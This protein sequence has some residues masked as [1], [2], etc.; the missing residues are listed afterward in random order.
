[1]AGVS[2]TALAAPLAAEAQTPTVLPPIEANVAP[3]EAAAA[4]LDVVITGEALARH[5]TA[6]AD[7]MSIITGTP[8]MAV[9]ANGGISSLPVMRGLADS[10]VLVSVDGAPITAFCPNGMNPP[11]SYVSPSRLESI[12]ILPTLSPVSAGGDNIAGVIALTTTAPTF[13]NPDEGLKVSGE[14]GATYR[15]VA[16]A[17]GASAQVTV[18]GPR[19]SVGYEA[20]WNRAENYRTGDGRRVR[21]TLYEAYEQALTLAWLT[22]Q[23]VLSLR[24]GKHFAPYEGFP[25]QRMDLTENDSTFADLRYEAAYGWG[26][27]TA[28]ASWREV[29]HE[30]NFLSDKGGSATGGMPMNSQGRD[31]SAALS[32][33]RPM[34]DGGALRAGLEAHRSD[35]DDW[36]PP[37]AGSAMMSPQT[38][39]NIADGRRDRTGVWAEW[40]AKPSAALTTL[41]GA[42]LER[43]ETD[44][45]LVQPYSWTGMMNAPDATAARIFNARDRSR[46]DDN[47]DLTAKAT[48][49]P[50]DVATLEFGY[51]RK[52]RSPNLYERYAWGVGDMSSS[53]TSFVGDGNGYVGDPD[54]KPEVAHHLA[55]TLRLVDPDGSRGL[56][57]SAYHSQVEDLIDA[58]KLA[59]LTRGFVKLR[60]ANVDARIYGF[61]ASGFVQAW[62]TEAFGRGILSGTLA[63]VD[64]ENRDSGDDLYHMT[65]LTARL[66]L[67]QSKG[68]WTNV[69]EVE[70][71]GEKD[72]VNALRHEPQT[73]AYALLNLR[74]SWKGERLR[75][76]L[77]AENLLDTSYDLPLGGMSYG[78]FRAGGYAVPIQPLPGPGRSINLGLTVSF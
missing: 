62:D 17:A 30:M 39:W 1:M 68:R 44:T 48:W 11:G 36:W 67:E 13:A 65:P 61:D 59:D 14:V 41:I 27:L 6:S 22:D 49:R 18:A 37:V 76:D 3:A 69:A 66:A 58:V 34:Q 47:V 4:P 19:L 10:R 16:D 12:A 60:F 70:L 35:L 15:S 38:Y 40:E 74:T 32:A 24:A 55:A 20:S 46:S 29:N 21:S 57:V 78:D 54:L 52:T 71:V 26:D 56:T 25:T 8:G 63:W 43:V 28:R 77:A 2:F 5:R 50:T 53:M 51:A 9:Y 64:G 45:G 42:R 33:S 72:A 31:L 75:V 73:S 7:T 23:G